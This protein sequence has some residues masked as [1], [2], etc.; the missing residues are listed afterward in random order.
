MA[1][2]AGVGLWA[3]PWA[4]M[5]AA[6]PPYIP[7]YIPLTPL[8]CPSPSSARCLHPIPLEKLLPR[9]RWPSAYFLHF[10]WQTPTLETLGVDLAQT[11]GDIPYAG[12]AAA[13]CAAG[14]AL[15]CL[16]C[17]APSISPSFLFPPLPC[18]E[19]PPPQEK[20]LRRAL[21]APPGFGDV[22]REVEGVAA[23]STHP[24]DW[25]FRGYDYE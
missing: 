10:P 2:W 22:L 18:N 13:P 12:E 1:L 15:L 8:P 20:L 19:N 16:C 14:P 7:P 6:A 9:S 21:P 11:V 5:R 17:H 24:G 4:E 25:R 23:A 3:Q